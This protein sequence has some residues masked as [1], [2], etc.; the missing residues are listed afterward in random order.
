MDNNRGLQR[1]IR[2]P[3]SEIFAGMPIHTIFHSQQTIAISLHHRT[4]RVRLTDVEPSC[5]KLSE[6]ELVARAVHARWRLAYDQGGFEEINAIEKP[7]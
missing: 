5:I 3:K 6:V 2:T 1:F 7:P 4:Q